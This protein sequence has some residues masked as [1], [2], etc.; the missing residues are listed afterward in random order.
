MPTAGSAGAARNEVRWTPPHHLSISPVPPPHPTPPLGP[1]RGRLRLPTTRP[2][3]SH[4]LTQLLLTNV[5]HRQRATRPHLALVNPPHPHHHEV[6][7]QGHALN[8]P[9]EL[10]RFRSGSEVIVPEHHLP[11]LVHSVGRLWVGANVVTGQWFALA[12]RAQCDHV[13]HL[14]F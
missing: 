4:R 9:L 1:L 14:V 6:Y 10:V 8:S 2:R 13:F 5:D 7:P 3:P 11:T 12:A